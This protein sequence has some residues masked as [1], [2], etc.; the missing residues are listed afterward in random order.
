MANRHGVLC[1]LG[2]NLQGRMSQRPAAPEST[3]KLRPRKEVFW[4]FLPMEAVSILIGYDT[5]GGLALI[6][7]ENDVEHGARWEDPGG[8]S[9]LIDHSASSIEYEGG[10]FNDAY[11]HT[12]MAQETFP[13]EWG[14]SG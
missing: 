12:G 11:T 3:W 10:I 14:K 5:P 4:L 9:R 1:L 7:S 8:P 2:F 13:A 6:P